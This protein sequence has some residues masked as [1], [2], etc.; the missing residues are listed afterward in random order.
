MGLDANAVITDGA[1]NGVL[2]AQLDYELLEP[3]ASPVVGE[4]LAMQG[5]NRV[6]GGW[7]RS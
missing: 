1:G 2:H 3:G 5:L 6:G 4:G 7:L